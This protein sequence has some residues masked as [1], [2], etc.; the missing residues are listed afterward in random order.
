RNGRI[1]R[2]GQK[3]TPMIWHPVGKG[4]KIN[5]AGARD[6]PGDIEGDH[7]YLMRAVLKV[8]A[9]REDL[10]SVGPVIADQIQQA[11]LGKRSDLD[12]RDA[13]NKAEKA[14]RFV[15]AER[16]LREKIAKLHER[17]IETRDDLELSP[18]RI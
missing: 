9:I 5:A 10:G 14:R 13:E 12:T 8:E 11:M 16:R 4:F 1:D 6:A 2:Y 18:E 17:L 3:K 15:A 7:E